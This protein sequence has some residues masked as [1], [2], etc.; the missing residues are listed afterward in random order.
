MPT[1]P[2][3]IAA[4]KKAWGKRSLEHLMVR[5]M[6]DTQFKIV[7]MG[8]DMS[9]QAVCY[10]HSRYGVPMSNAACVNHCRVEP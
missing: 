4:L 2:E 5:Y 7:S 3:D 9:L 1:D 6:A 10:Y 8:L